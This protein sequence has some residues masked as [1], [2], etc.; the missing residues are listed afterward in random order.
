MDLFRLQI[1]SAFHEAT[2]YWIRISIFLILNILPLMFVIFHPEQFQKLRRRFFVMIVG[3][4]LVGLGLQVSISSKAL[5]QAWLE[6]AKIYLEQ[7]P[8]IAK[9][10][11]HSLS[12]AKI[13]GSHSKETT[14]DLQA[15]V[16]EG[17][18]F[19]IRFPLF[20]G[21]STTQCAHIV[22]VLMGFFWLI[23]GLRIYP[24]YHCRSVENVS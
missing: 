9:K 14:V 7:D 4:I 5:G 15:F 3:F 2:L 20:D 18:I 24:R 11:H 21:L 23:W 16:R 12:V 17:K 6:D 13:P 8:E 10:L 19:W 22:F 1:E